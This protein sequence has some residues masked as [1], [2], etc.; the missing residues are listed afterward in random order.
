M[1]PRKP[2]KRSTKPIKRTSLKRGLGRR[3]KERLDA[4]QIAKNSYYHSWGYSCQFC[5]CQFDPSEEKVDA[6]HK[7][8][9]SL[10]GTDDFTN[11]VILHRVC[12]N[13]IHR[14]PVLLKKVATSKA[15]I[16]D[17]ELICLTSTPS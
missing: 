11:L 8:K 5:G 17:G 4:M 1:K 16:L 13:A 14:D 7:L 2:L 12:H 3:G 9:R 10:G 15:N 6:H